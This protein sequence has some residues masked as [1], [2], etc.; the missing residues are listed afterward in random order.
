MINSENR[1]KCMEHCIVCV[2]GAARPLLVPVDRCAATL[3]APDLVPLAAG[4]QHHH[5]PP[6]LGKVP[7]AAATQFSRMVSPGRLRLGM[8]S[9]KYF[10]I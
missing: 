7:S 10:I 3:H 8:S 4:H 5:L 1:K 6:P 2:S 9:P